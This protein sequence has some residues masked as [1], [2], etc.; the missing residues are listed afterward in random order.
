MTTKKGIV[1]S[2]FEYNRFRFNNYHPNLRPSRLLTDTEKENMVNLFKLSNLSMHTIY[3]DDWL[4]IQLDAKID[5]IICM[6]DKSC[7]L[8]RRVIDR[9]LIK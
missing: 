2:V 6:K 4:S 8:Y 9:K 3:V 7:D 5:D 1:N